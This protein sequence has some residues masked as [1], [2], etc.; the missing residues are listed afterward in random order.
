MIVGYFIDPVIIIIYF[1][2]PLELEGL[3]FMYD[4]LT[5]CDMHESFSWSHLCDPP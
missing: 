4:I 2:D 5:L 1:I 3:L